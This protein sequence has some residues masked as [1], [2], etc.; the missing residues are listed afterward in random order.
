MIKIE[1][2][3]GI[4]II[5]IVGSF[6]I[7]FQLVGWF[8]I[9]SSFS[10]IWLWVVAILLGV[11]FNLITK[12]YIKNSVKK[13]KKIDPIK[14][15]HLDSKFNHLLIC[16]SQR[17]ETPFTTSQSRPRYIINNNTKQAYWVSTY[18][19]INI[20]GKSNWHTFEGEKAIMN[21]FKEHRITFNNRDP[22]IEELG[23]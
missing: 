21:Y 14:T 1:F 9:M 6:T 12:D 15:Q 5:I 10:D 23:L 17:T 2:L 20:K 7:I 8:D 19:D 16:F 18:V 13:S 3:L 22:T 11:A 4:A